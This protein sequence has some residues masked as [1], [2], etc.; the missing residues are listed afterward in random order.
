MSAVTWS[1]ARLCTAAA[2][3]SVA[4]TAALGVAVISA[5]TDAGPGAAAPAGSAA[6]QRAKSA[7]EAEQTGPGSP[8]GVPTR[9]SGVDNGKDGKHIASDWMSGLL[10]IPVV[11]GGKDRTP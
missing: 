11:D 3:I 6:H 5:F 2:V 4:A 7:A 10:R 8:V 9:H 1:R